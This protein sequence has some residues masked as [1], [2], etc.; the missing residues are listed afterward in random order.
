M[1]TCCV[2]GLSLIPGNS[3]GRYGLQKAVESQE[4]DYVSL[5]VLFLLSEER[6]VPDLPRKPPSWKL[7]AA[8][9]RGL[10]PNL[11]LPNKE[12]SVLQK[13]LACASYYS[14]PEQTHGPIEQDV[15]S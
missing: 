15:N 4:W 9:S 1:S 11:R 10:C 5:F 6:E 12:T 7:T 3:V 13:S 14:S 2:L 8:L